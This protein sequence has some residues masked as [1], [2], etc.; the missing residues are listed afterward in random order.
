MIFKRLLSLNNLKRSAYIKEEIQAE[1]I[2]R[3]IGAFQ[4][5]LNVAA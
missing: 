5:F 3:N 1:A 4:R 2:T